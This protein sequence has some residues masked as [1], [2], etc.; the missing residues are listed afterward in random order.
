[1]RQIMF[2]FLDNSIFFNSL[3]IASPFNQTSTQQSLYCITILLKLYL[4]GSFVHLHYAE[5]VD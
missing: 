5:N 2:G 3:A 1:M 4:P